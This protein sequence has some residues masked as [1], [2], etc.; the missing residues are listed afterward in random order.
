MA[1]E[2][3][4]KGKLKPGSGGRP[5]GARNKLQAGF[6]EALQEDFMEHGAATIEIVR[7]ERPAEFLKIIAS[8]LPKEFV[9][10]DNAAGDLSDEEITEA[11]AVLRQL[12]KQ[13]NE[14][15]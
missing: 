15:A 13:K 1:F 3:D 2:R 5:A 8:V 4:E 6:V 12:R 10:P 11:L 9:M 7:K 14:A